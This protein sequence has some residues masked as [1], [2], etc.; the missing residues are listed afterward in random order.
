MEG[1]FT[2]LLSGVI[3]TALFELLRVLAKNRDRL[4]LLGATCAKRDDPIRVSAAYLFRIMVDGRYLLIKGKRIQS[5]YQPVGGVYKR[6]DGS[7]ELFN[8]L[9]VCGGADR[10]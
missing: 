3:G 10:P 5:Q 6:F 4:R 1:F 9:G 8:K 7:A 2:G